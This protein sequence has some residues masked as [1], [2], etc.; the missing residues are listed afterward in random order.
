[1]YFWRTAAKQEIDYIEVVLGKISAF[2]FKWNPKTKKKFSH[3][4]LKS[5]DVKS[6]S[7]INRENFERFLL[8]N[9][10]KSEQ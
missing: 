3:T 9:N 7:I 6:T 5:Y 10:R 8:A 2:K 1:M 4:F